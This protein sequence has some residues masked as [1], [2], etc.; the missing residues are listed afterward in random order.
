MKKYLVILLVLII[1]SC[2]TDSNEASIDTIAESYV[3]LVLE[4]GQYDNAFVDAYFGPEEWRPTEPKS[5][6]LPLDN[7][8]QRTNKLIQQCEALLTA[9]KPNLEVARINMLI[10]QLISVRTKT[11]M[12]SGKLY[13]FDEE[14]KLLYDAEPPHFP[15]SHFDEL[16]KGLDDLLPGKGDL[17]SRYNAFMKDFIIPKEKLDTVFRVAIDASRKITK[18][19]FDLPE[20][21]NFV[22]GYV[23]DKVWSGYNY[24]QGNAQSLIEINTDFPIYISRAVD[25]A[26]HEG[27]PGHHIYMMLT[28]Q[29]LVKTKGWFEFSVYP[30]FS[31]LSLIAEG[32]AN[33]G[34]DVVFP[35]D[36][37]INFEK[38][39][40]FPLAGIDTSKAEKFYSVQEVMG[41]LN[42]ARNEVARAY[43]NG[44]LSRENAIKQIEKYSLFTFEKAE[45]SVRFIEANRSYVINYNLG[46]DLVAKHV[47]LNGGTYSNPDKRWEVFKE[48]LS[49]P[50]SASTL[51]K[52]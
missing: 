17:S 40:L 26:S 21:E 36:K 34:I 31:P 28:E 44:D 46:K 25:L 30:L 9:N 38:E 45:Q 41:K 4:I 52:E 32:S 8:V 13:S 29:N 22:L 2:K 48:L 42:Y 43:L 27:Y 16:L 20:N 1:A 51:R 35:G 19:K 5:E 6:I 10:K 39:Y 12:I 18:N 23:T 7:F 33:Y 37:R 11:E 49:N 47:E 15:M 50:Y 3:K 24:F 14:A